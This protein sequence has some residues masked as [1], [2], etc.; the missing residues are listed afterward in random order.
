MVARQQTGGMDATS[1]LKP[2]AVTEPDRCR[3]CGRRE[4]ESLQVVSRHLTSTGL[5]IYARCLCGLLHMWHSPLP[6]G[7]A[8]V[9]AHAAQPA[10]QPPSAGPWN[11]PGT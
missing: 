4:D 10:A 6:I 3:W 9:S 11:R 8:A 5:T 1:P 2:K 7:R